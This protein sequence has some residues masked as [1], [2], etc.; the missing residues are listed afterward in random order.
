MVLPPVVVLLYD[1]TGGF[2]FHLFFE[3]EIR[4]KDLIEEYDALLSYP[5][6]RYPQVFA[7]NG[8]MFYDLRDQI[9]ELGLDDHPEVKKLD[10]QFLKK[11]L[12]WVHPDD[13]KA[14]KKY[15]NMWWH[16]L[17]EIKQ[18]TYPKEKLPEHLKDLISLSY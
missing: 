13:Y 17:Q 9:H 2:L 6:S 8:W 15:P 16:N 1:T 7:Y 10:R 4:V 12:E 3:L 5:N 18:G 14:E 11:V